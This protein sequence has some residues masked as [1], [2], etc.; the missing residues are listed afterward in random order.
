[1]KKKNNE[2]VLIARHI[3]NWLNEYVSSTCLKSEHTKRTYE[4]TLSLYAKFLED[5]KELLLQKY[6]QNVFQEYLWKNG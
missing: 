2:A 4:V 6:R 3:Y 1:M 5:K